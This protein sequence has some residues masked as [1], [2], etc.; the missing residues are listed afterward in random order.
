MNSFWSNDSPAYLAEM[1]GTH[2]AYPW[3]NPLYTSAIAFSGQHRCQHSCSPRHSFSGRATLVAAVVAAATEAADSSHISN[4]GYCRRPLALLLW[5]PLGMN[6]TD[7]PAYHLFSCSDYRG[8][9]TARI[10]RHCCCSSES[11]P[12]LANQGWAA[13]G[14]PMHNYRQS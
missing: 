7:H 9:R 10:H 14:L 11:A 13:M 1:C 12:V 8:N 6:R 4:T 3:P 2:M 5:P